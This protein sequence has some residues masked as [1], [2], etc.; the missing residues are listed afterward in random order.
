MVKG[1]TTMENNTQTQE[2]EQKVNEPST[3]VE[4]EQVK[5]RLKRVEIINITSLIL[6][7]VLI[8]INLMNFGLRVDEKQPSGPQRALPSD[9]SAQMRDK[10]AD[11]IASGYN[12]GDGDKLYSLLGDYAQTLITVE[13]MNDT[14]DTLK[15]L[16]SLEKTSY[17][18]YEFLGDRDGAEWFIL[19]YVAKYENGNGTLRVTLRVVDD[20]WEIA[21]FYLNVD[22]LQKSN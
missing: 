21:G 16:G 7:V 1:G 6:I 14:V 12:N 20:Q 10:I 13:E 8:G 9:V 3:Q 18:Y 17:S 2:V 19:H 4:L 5:K 22:Q 11:D 15:V